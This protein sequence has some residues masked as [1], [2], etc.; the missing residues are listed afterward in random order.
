MLDE[1]Q[2]YNPANTAQVHY[3]INK[4]RCFLHVS[5]NLHPPTPIDVVMRISN[6]AINL[7]D[8]HYSPWISS[9][10]PCRRRRHQYDQEPDITCTPPNVVG[11]A[12]PGSIRVV[13]R[14]KTSSHAQ[15]HNHGMAIIILAGD[16]AQRCNRAIL[17]AQIR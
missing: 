13:Y 14:G 15:I 4:K 5:V 1:L 12:C 7:I 11:K 9:P 8:F 3:Y 6:F 17:Y 2:F 16:P 10:V